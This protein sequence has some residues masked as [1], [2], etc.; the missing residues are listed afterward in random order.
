MPSITFGFSPVNFPHVNLILCPAGRTLEGG[1]EFLLPD[2]RK[3]YISSP[4]LYLLKKTKK[5][6]F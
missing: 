1:P 6:T 2:R 4:G 3:K 5:T